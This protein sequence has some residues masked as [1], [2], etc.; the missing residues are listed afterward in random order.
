MTSPVPIVNTVAFDCLDP[1]RLAQFWGALL[2]VKEPFRE[3]QFVWLDR[4][5]EGAYSLMFEKVTDP[6]PGKN[7]STLI[8]SARTWN[9]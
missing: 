8:A 9:R 6:T 1:E 5:R 7:N 2:G 4:Q 3:E